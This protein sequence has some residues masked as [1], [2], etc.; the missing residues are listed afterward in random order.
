MRGA[1]AE[2]K[3]QNAFG[4]FVGSPSMRTFVTPN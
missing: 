2:V 4:A 1:Y 3:P